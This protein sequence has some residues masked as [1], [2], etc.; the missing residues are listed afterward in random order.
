MEGIVTDQQNRQLLQANIE[1]EFA[2]FLFS[3]SLSLVFLCLK[4]YH[5]DNEIFW[6]TWLACRLASKPW[7]T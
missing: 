4:A 7:G 6:L 1:I 3:L 5:S 2:S